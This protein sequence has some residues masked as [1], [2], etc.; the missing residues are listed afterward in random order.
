MCTKIVVSGCPCSKV[1]MTK[2]S[3]KC[4]LVFQLGGE[5]Y[6]S[7]RNCMSYQ[8]DVAKCCLGQKR[9]GGYAVK[10][11][12]MFFITPDK[13]G[14]LPAKRA[15]LDNYIKAAQDGLQYGG[16]FLPK[17]NKAEKGDDKCVVMYG[18]GTGVYP[19]KEGQERT[20]ITLEE[21]S[22]E[23]YNEYLKKLV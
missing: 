3:V 1:R 14:G 9:V 11:T 18:E 12:Y 23:Q 20:V 22:K 17:S 13:K 5:P 10:A 7:I 19:A 2:Q 15:D 6:E 21:L 16:I 4:A 8:Q